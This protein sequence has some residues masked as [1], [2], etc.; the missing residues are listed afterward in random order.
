MTAPAA[1]A[2]DGAYLCRLLGAE[3][4]DEQ[5]AVVIAPLAPQ[6]VVAGAGSGKTT[7]M[8]ARVV[9]A[10]AWHGL[11]PASVLGLTFTNKAAAELAAKVRGSLRQLGP[12]DLPDVVRGVD[13]LPTVSTYHAYAA[14]IL[15]DHAMRIGREPRATLL[16]EAGRWQ[17]AGRVV[18]QARG[19]FPDLPWTPSSV[20]R[21]VL[22]LDAEL[23]EHLVGLDALRALDDRVAKEIGGLAKS[24]RLL[25]DVAAAARARDQL[26][27]LV[28]AYRDRKRSVEA[29]DFGD[30]VA[31]A[32]Q[33]AASYPQVGQEERAEHRLVL[34]DEYQDTGVAQR[35]LLSLLYAKDHAVTAVGDPCQSIYGWRGASVGNLL[36]F[37]EHFGGAGEPLQLSTNFRSGGR[38]LEVANAVSADLRVPRHPVAGA[39]RPHVPVGELRPRPGAETDGE[40]R[41]ALLPTAPQEA[42]WVADQVASAVEGGTSPGQVAVLCRRR[43]DFALLHERLVARGLPVEVVGLGGLLDVPEVADVT[44]TL[45]VLV[46]PTANPALVRLLTGPRWA[47]GPRD[48]AALGRRAHRLAAAGAPSRVAAGEDPTGAA[49][50]AQAT[51]G[52][53][54]TDVPSLSEAVE[55]PG[56]PADYSAEAL[57]RFGL[58]AREILRLRRVLE[59]PV[60]EAVHEIVATIGLDVEL[61]AGGAGTPGARGANLAAFLDHAASFG[62]RQSG[63]AGG[64]SDPR[65]FLDW[66]AAAREAEDGLDVGG[67]S[68]ADTVKLLTVHKAKGL[69][70]DVVAV[71]GL[72]VGT[73][74]ADRGRSLWTGHGRVLPYSLRGDADDL[75]ADPVEWTTKAVEQFRAHCR[76]ESTEEERRLAYVAVTRAKRLLLVS[77]H[78]W[79]P[80]R[81]QPR[82]P[83]DYL[84]EVRDRLRASGHGEVTWSESDEEAAEG[85]VN[86]LLVA[87]QDTAWPAVGGAGART[88]RRW[89]ADRVLAALAGAVGATA[90]GLDEDERALVRRWE[91]EADLLLAEVAEE[92]VAVHDV[93]VPRSLSTSQV[94]RL[95][96]DPAGLARDLA[97]PMP[98]RPSPAARRGTRF[99]AWVEGMF[100]DRPLIAA[101]ELTGADDGVPDDADLGALRASFERSVYAGVRPHR[102]EAA[103]QLV[104]GSHLVRGRIDAVYAVGDG[105]WDVI[106]YKTGGRPRD[107]TA[108]ALQLA[109]YRLAWAGIAGVPAEDVAAGFLYVRTGE[110]VRPPDLPD[111]AGLTRLLD[112]AGRR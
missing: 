35:V 36:R 76:R 94:V 53:D 99:H 11:A 56:D 31:L 75:P 9:H 62:G 49:A 17:L 33:I 22:E 91:H 71:P 44:A 103:F 25:L 106:D 81:R 85:Q 12:A 15:A 86:P 63:G 7:V 38:L 55:S 37:F 19:P 65:A 97:R 3:F 111:L 108:A 98:R 10:V 112:V 4:T 43:A 90:D 96:S 92:R 51:A 80:T 109:V 107:A 45:E 69:E 2:A 68:T 79:S 28:Q 6:L 72:V 78:R 70:W 104:A 20:T 23:S 46:D 105:G 18:R 1:P 13:D 67:V 84:L 24:T 64:Q 74:P 101:E 83:A 47:I 102:V 58:L 100:A 95:G 32:A 61:A 57:A 40:A 48:L 14:R 34:L 110:V 93:Q 60:V 5:L 30:Q 21:Y 82:R 50:L 52:V 29:V 77:G 59:Q 87:P 66:L 8:A 88:R 73:F 27:E 16:T 54:P 26:L 39:R 89:A 41:C 42:E